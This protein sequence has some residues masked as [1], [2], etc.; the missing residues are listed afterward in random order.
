MI[1]VFCPLFFCFSNAFVLLREALVHSHPGILTRLLC[2][3]S[4]VGA[5]LISSD[6]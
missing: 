2:S 5:L 1:S 4:V 6:G 3:G